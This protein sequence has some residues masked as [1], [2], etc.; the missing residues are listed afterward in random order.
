MVAV[1]GRRS[2][3]ALSRFCAG[4]AIL[5]SPDSPSYRAAVE[6]ELLERPY[7]TVLAA[8]DAELV[9]LQRSGAGLVDKELLPTFAAAAGLQVPVTRS[10]FRPQ[11]LHAKAMDL[12]YPVV[13]KATVKSTAD[14]VARRIDSPAALN[15]IVGRLNGP[16]VVQPFHTGRMRAVAG[17][18]HG[19]VLL[20]VVHQS[21]VRIWPVDCGV[22]CAAIT[23][24]P[25]Y[26][27]EARLPL[28]LHGHT[29]VFQ[30]QLVGDHL[31][32]V[33]PRVYGSLP[34]AVAAGVNLPAIACALL[35][36]RIEEPVRGAA[37]VKYRWLEGDLRRVLHDVRS[38]QLGLAGAAAAL[39][40][41]RGMAHSI[42]SIQDPLPG[43]TRLVEV[44]RRR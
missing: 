3:A 5:P 27:L 39:R 17:V 31:I 16:L 29:G 8:S 26:E 7:L 21:Y 2:S 23:T 24:S 6:R 28:L 35:Q 15:A 10:F 20:A 18:I 43:L 41:R 22:A 4:V 14:A 36:G 19:G 30:V 34:L 37:G 38:R 40:P 9:T 33:N 25:D 44:C 11:E 12:D 1:S 42:E 13:V 32:D